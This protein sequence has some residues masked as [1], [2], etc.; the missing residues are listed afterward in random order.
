VFVISGREFA[1]GGLAGDPT[2]DASEGIWDPSSVFAGPVT[3][4]KCATT[5]SEYLAALRRRSS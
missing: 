5:T 3:S 1:F 2:I 4:E